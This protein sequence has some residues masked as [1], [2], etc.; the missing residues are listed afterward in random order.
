MIATIGWR[1]LG[2]S[3]L[4]GHH[5]APGVQP[6]RPTYRGN[7]RQWG[8]AHRHHRLCPSTKVKGMISHH[9]SS[10]ICMSIKGG[11]ILPVFTSPHQWG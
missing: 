2:L 10:I 6:S 5:A 4:R 11:H 3:H 1:C 7:R 8:R 9:G